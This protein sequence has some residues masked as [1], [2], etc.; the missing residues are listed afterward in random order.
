MKNKKTRYRIL[1]II[2]IPLVIICILLAVL[3]VTSL[4]SAVNITGPAEMESSIDDLGYHLRSDAT[5]LQKT[6]FDELT[7]ALNA[8]E[9][10]EELI[11][12]SIVKNFVA[13]FYT[14]TNKEGQYDIGGMDYVY[15]PQKTNI[16][17][18]A[19]NDFYKTFEQSVEAYGQDETLEIDEVSASAVALSGGYDL[20][21]D[22]VSVHFSDA[23]TVDCDFSY[24]D[25][26]MDKSALETRQT[27]IVIKDQETGRYES[28][29]ALGGEDVTQE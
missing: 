21:E 5:D 15:T 18:E 28:V 25:T 6:L 26:D 2:I 16:Y 27:F 13:D 29:E 24:A 10:D 1:G 3:A 9:E 11:A 8:E 7:E 19:R 22:G 17:D 20:E 14:W 4:K 12:E 23:F